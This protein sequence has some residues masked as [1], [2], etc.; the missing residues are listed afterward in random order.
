MLN[1][2]DT[3]GKVRSC[4]EKP[5]KDVNG[6]AGLYEGVAGRLDLLDKAVNFACDAEARLVGAFG[7]ATRN[8]DCR[9]DRHAGDVGELSGVPDF[10]KDEEGPVLLNVDG[11]L[12]VLD[13][14]CA[15]A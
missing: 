12:R 5:L 10:A 7:I 14:L 2:P 15:E 1:L 8:R 6:I 9:L 11:N 3:P 4:S 13:V